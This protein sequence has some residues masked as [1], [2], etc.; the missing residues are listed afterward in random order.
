[1]SEFELCYEKHP[2]YLFVKGKGTR[3]N[4]GEIFE[5]TQAL[6]RIVE[7]ND[8]KFILLDYS[9]TVTHT[10]NIDVFNITRL[11]ETKTPVMF[12]LCISIITNP[13]EFAQ[14]AFWEDLCRK[15]GFNFK[16]FTDP[17]EAKSWLLTQVRKN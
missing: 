12:K 15:R 1:M 5:S 7:E 3:K 2:Q 17:G 16:I 4:L 10:S 8:S 9:E 11:Y 6:A 13:V 14:D